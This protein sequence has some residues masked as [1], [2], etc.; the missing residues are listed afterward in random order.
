MSNPR[1]GEVHLKMV[2]GS[3]LHLHVP[4]ASVKDGP[5]KYRG[6]FLI[7]PESSTGR[8]NIKEI[9]R[10][11]EEAEEEEFGKTGLS[12]KEGRCAYVEGNDCQNEDGQIYDGYED[13]MVVKGN[14][15]KKIA[16]RDRDG[17]TALDE[18]DGKTYSGAYYNVIGRFYGVSGKD[19]GGNGLF[20][21]IDGIQ[22][23]KHG[24]AFGGGGFREGSFEDIGDDEDEDDRPQKKSRSRDDDDEDERPR[25]K[26]KAK[27][28]DDEEDDEDEPP[29]KK[30]KSRSRNDDEDEDER[31]RKKSKPRRSRDDDDDEDEV[32]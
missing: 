9:E 15:N 4:R 26:A 22:F 20:F 21:N 17:V 14:N 29:K 10:A 18:E 5:K 16:L 25:K 32:I 12:Y 31:P 7:D 11:M 1:P 24:D 2:R 30:A 19:K 27:V 6:N 23:V 8:K 3:Y 13:M 28:R